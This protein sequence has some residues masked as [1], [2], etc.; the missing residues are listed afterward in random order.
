MTVPAVIVPT[1]TLGILN[2]TVDGFS[3]LFVCFY[4]VPC[5]WR[6]SYDW[7]TACDRVRQ[8][9]RLVAHWAARNAH[10]P[11][12]PLAPLTPSTTRTPTATLGI[13]N[14]SVAWFSKLFERWDNPPVPGG[15]VTWSADGI[16]S[17]DF[18][19]WQA[20]YDVQ[21]AVD[22]GIQAERLTD[23]WAARDNYRPVTPL[24]PPAP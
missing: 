17:Y 8:G 1:A 23:H 10:G 12:T 9:E 15:R 6:W 18:T 13:L 7:R 3:D 4:P 24:T 21:T 14:P 5:E 11:V 16:P 2:P 22:R 20:S 19:G